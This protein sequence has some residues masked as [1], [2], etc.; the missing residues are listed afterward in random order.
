SDPRFGLDKTNVTCAGNDGTLTVNNLQ[1]GR[2]PFTYTIIAPSPSGTGTTNS[3]GAFTNLVAGEYF[4]QLRDSC[5]GIQVRRATIEQYNW[6]FGAITVT[7]VGCDSADAVITLNDNRGANNTSGSAFSGFTYGV[8]R[9]AGDTSW[10]PSNRFR[11]FLGKRRSVT[12]I[13]KDDCGNIHSTVWTL[14]ANRRPSVTGVNLTNFVCS[15][16]AADV[17]G[18][19]NLTAPEYCLYT[20]AN[21]FIDC[22]Y[23][24]YFG[25]LP[26]GSYCIRITDACYDTTIVQC[27]TANRPTPGVGSSVGISA[28][29]CTTFT[30]TINGQSNLTAPEYCLYNNLDALITCN[31]TGVFTDLPYGSYCIKTEDNCTDTI[32][33]RCFTATKPIPVL[34]APVIGGSTC[35]SFNVS[36]TGTGLTTPL[37]CL[38]DSAGNVVACDS[39]GN[40][41]GVP[42]GNYCIRAIVCGDT[43]APRCFSSGPPVP[44]VAA[45]V[46]ISNRTCTGFTATIN[47]QTNLS[48][49]QYCLFDSTNTPVSCNTTGVFPGI[50]YGPYCIQVKDSCTDSTITRCFTATRTLP[51]VNATMQ[52]TAST[53]STFSARVT[54]SNLTAP[55]YCLYDSLN[56]MVSCNTTG[57]FDN[58]PYGRY[59]VRVENSCGDTFRV[60]QTFVPVKGL[61]ITT[62]KSCNIGN[63]SIN[64]QFTSNNAPYIVRIVH[65]NGVTVFTDTSNTDPVQAVLPALPPG[66]SYK[67]YGQDG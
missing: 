24:G 52:Q 62:A 3:T 44:S 34:N 54:G 9:D 23:T 13:A 32:I 66:L 59:C 25:L 55:Q 17:T 36:V 29:N 40:F 8:V 56:L 12:I 14:P 19:Q 28:Q 65:P 41:T 57:I 22:N 30:A 2:N 53:C 39:S 63:A 43:T 45:S 49:P 10:Y 50:P 64:V 31:T 27:F 48:A 46:Q 33:T 42:H 38:Y 4:I 15:T 61:S 7:K 47:G 51:T 21:V 1:F 26:Y 20:S 18:E 67:I 16:F 35:G 11:F 6:W 60:C 37:Y 5:G 58:L